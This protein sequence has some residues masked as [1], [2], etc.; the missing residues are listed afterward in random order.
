[1]LGSVTTDRSVASAGADQQLH[2]CSLAVLPRHAQRR[3]PFDRPRFSSTHTPRLTFAPRATSSLT[4][5]RW[6][7]PLAWINALSSPGTSCIGICTTVEQQL[8]DRERTLLARDDQRAAIALD[9]HVHVGATVEQVPNQRQLA[10]PNGADQRTAVAI[11]RAVDV[12]ASLEQLVHFVEIAVLSRFIERAVQRARPSPLQDGYGRTFTGLTAV[13]ARNVAPIADFVSLRRTDECNRPKRRDRDH[14]ERGRDS[15]VPDATARPAR[16]RARLSSSNAVTRVERSLRL[17]MPS[18]AARAVAERRARTP[19]ARVIRTLLVR[20]TASSQARSASRHNR[21][22]PSR[23]AGGTNN[24][25][26]PHAHQLTA[27]SSRRACSNSWARAQR[28]R[29]RP[30]A[31]I[32]R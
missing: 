7:D 28:R 16:P 18:T 1:M 5:S 10:G 21:E 20:I 9:W 24:T 12:G 11:H 19:T 8:D 3:A 22:A 26:R 14:C 29:R 4:T 32:G 2:D 31:C 25:H 6:P 27:Q 30:F 17:A 23:P 13:N 15:T